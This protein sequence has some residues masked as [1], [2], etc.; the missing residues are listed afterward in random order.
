MP[1]N[2]ISFA[3][4]EKEEKAVPTWLTGVQQDELLRDGVPVVV[5]Q[6]PLTGKFGAVTKDDADKFGLTIKRQ[7]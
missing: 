5:C 6:N 7:M 3:G 1:Q 2:L 4:S